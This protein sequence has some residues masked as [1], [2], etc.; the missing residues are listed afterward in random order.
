MKR[1]DIVVGNTYTDGKGNY[2]EVLA[3]G[4]DYKFYTA[5]G[6]CDC[7]RYQLIAKRRG[8]YNV[9]S[10]RNCTRI[11]FAAWAKLKV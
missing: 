5:Q 10:Q 8:P 4:P 1:G 11:S 3:V 9:G 6:D 2:R 7:I